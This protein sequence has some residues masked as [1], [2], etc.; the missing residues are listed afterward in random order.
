VKRAG[1]S[2]KMMVEVSYGGQRGYELV[3]GEVSDK[4]I[5]S[6][7]PTDVRLT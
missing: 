6:A 7:G 1:V 3:R 2:A 4:W 5:V